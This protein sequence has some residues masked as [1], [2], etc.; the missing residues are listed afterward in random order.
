MTVPSELLFHQKMISYD[1]SFFYILE[2]TFFLFCTH[3]NT[4]TMCLS[5]ILTIDRENAHLIVLVL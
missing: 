5:N 2:T 4:E 3:T 1:F